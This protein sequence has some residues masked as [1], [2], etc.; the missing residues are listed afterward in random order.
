MEFRMIENMF[1]SEDPS[2]VEKIYS[3]DRNSII[4][5]MRKRETA[6]MKVFQTGND[7]VAVVIPTADVE[8]QRAKE[9]MRIFSGAKI[10][11][12]E[13]KGNFFNYARSVNK[14]VSVALES[15]PRWV[16]ISNDDVHGI[17]SFKKL[18]DELSTSNKG[19]V[20]AKPSRYHSYK[21]SLIEVKPYFLKGMYFIGKFMRIPP[22]EVYGYLQM[23]YGAKLGVKTLTIIDSMI[24][25]MKNFAG[26]VKDSF[27]NAGSFM[28]LNRRV[29]NGKVFDETFI[30]G[31]EDVYLSMK[32]RNDMEIVNFRIDEERGASLGFGKLRFYRSFVNE[33]YLNYLLW[34]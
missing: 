34:G 25:L 5:W 27:I 28:V 30:N 31:Y 18:K 21:V 32:M 20:L 19:M 8:S 2:V 16:V 1:S 23:K 4:E 26:E 24:G 12:V 10:V 6:Q 11:M 9:S 33:I 17:D 7:D 29:I 14:G 22:A 13:S 15:S 3:L